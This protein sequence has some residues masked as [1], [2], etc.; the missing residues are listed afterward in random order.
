[1][2]L[3]LV[4]ILILCLTSLT[5]ADD[6]VY[7][8]TN[9]GYLFDAESTARI[10]RELLER[11]EMVKIISAQSDI[12]SNQSNWNEWNQERMKS[13]QNNLKQQKKEATKNSVKSF[14]RGSAFG[15]TMTAIA[16]VLMIIL[17]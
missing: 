13:L 16:A 2:R 10:A 6:Y 15:A 11:K 12:I 7:V 14:F 4:P 17:I 1:M 3:A 5:V 8:K 9:G